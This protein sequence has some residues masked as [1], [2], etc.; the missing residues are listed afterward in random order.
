MSSP[1]SSSSSSPSRAIPS[2]PL[3]LNGGAYHAA[4]GVSEKNGCHVSQP[5][6]SPA[7][8]SARE[9]P[10]VDSG[11]HLYSKVRQRYR[12]P[13][14]GGALSSRSSESSASSTLTETTN[15]HHFDKEEE[16]KDVSE[17]IFLQNAFKTVRW[18]QNGQ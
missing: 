18:R 3:Q 10:V 16:S 9:R 13:M 4:N 8:A 6:L 14:N 1:S 2:V 7:P 11:Q 15:G 17:N 5:P 12:S